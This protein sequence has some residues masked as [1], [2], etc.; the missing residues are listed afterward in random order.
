LA[1][2]RISIAPPLD[3]DFSTILHADLSGFVRLTEGDETSPTRISRRR[4]A[5]SGGRPSKAPR[6]LAKQTSCPH[7]GGCGTSLGPPPGPVLIA[8]TDCQRVATARDSKPDDAG[9]E[10]RPST[11]MLGEVTP[12]PI[13]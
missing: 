5:R 7:R 6:S 12:S 9:R 8:S 4:A 10:L 1:W 11:C 3:A 13:H 2:F